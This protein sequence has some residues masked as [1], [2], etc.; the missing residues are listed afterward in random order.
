MT[1][2]QFV[3]V[4]PVSTGPATPGKTGTDS[5]AIYTATASVAVTG[6]PAFNVEVA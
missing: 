5:A 6:T 4:V 2:G 3:D 1:A